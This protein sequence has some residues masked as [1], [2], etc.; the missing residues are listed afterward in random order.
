MWCWQRLPCGVFVQ[1]LVF[2]SVICWR[3]WSDAKLRIWPGFTLH[4]VVLFLTLALMRL[5]VFL[6]PSTAYIST[7][8]N[9]NL[10]LHCRHMLSQSPSGIYVNDNR[11]FAVVLLPHG[12][13]SHGWITENRY[14]I[15]SIPSTYTLT[16][17]RSNSLTNQSYSSEAFIIVAT[18]WSSFPKS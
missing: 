8:V 4:V 7:V 6:Y 16:T 14:V 2:S 11:G 15:G 13:S 10:R 18:S 3:L 5:A 1:V 17:D 9:S 12:L